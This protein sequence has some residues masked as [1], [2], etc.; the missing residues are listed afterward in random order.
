MSKI[1]LS[2]RRADSLEVT[3]RIYDELCPVFG[4]DTIFRDMDTI[5]IGDFRRAITQ[6]LNQ[7]RVAL[8]IIGQKWLNIRDD[9]TGRLRLFDP[10]DYVRQEVEVALAQ[11]NTKVVPLLVQGATMPAEKQLPPTLANLA[12]QNAFQVDS[13][14][15]FHHDMAWLI[16]YMEP[17]VPKEV[18]PR[19]RQLLAQGQ[20]ALLSGDYTLAEMYLKEADDLLR[21]PAMKEEAARV[22]YLRAL[23]QLEGSRPAFQASSVMQSVETMLKVAISLHGLASYT[24]TLG[25]FNLDFGSRNG[26]WQV[27]ERGKSMLAQVRQ[28]AKTAADQERIRLLSQAQ[29]ELA[30]EYL[31]WW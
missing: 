1:F 31:R 9:Q 5:G 3:A 19:A 15:N 23:N 22:K 27:E 14:R 2:Y 10:G 8:V 12:F 18:S 26:F 21:E 7:S 24:F 28:L 4:R 16:K 30:R 20:Q 11:P 13:N 6:A 25:V 17:L 29:P